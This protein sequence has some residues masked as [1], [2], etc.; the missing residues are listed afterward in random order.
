MQATRF[1][2]TAVLLCA[3]SP[4]HAQQPVIGLIT[5]TETNPFFVKMREG[6]T[7]AAKAKG[8]RLMTAAGRFDGDNASQ[9]TAIENMVAAG[10]KA[11][12]ITPSDTKAIV[13]PI[14]KARAAGVL[15]IALDSPTDPQDATDALFATDNFKAGMLIGRYAKAATAGKPAKIAM[16]DLAPGITVGTLRHDGFLQG[17][18]IKDGD[19][20]IV[21][22]ADTQGDQ[23]KGQTAMENCLQRA[24]QIDV[25]YTINE[26]AAAG[27]YRALRAAG[28]EKQVLI[29]SVDGGCAGVRNV[30]AGT[31]AATSQQYPLKMAALGVEAAVEYAKTGKK[32]TGT[33]DTG[34]T[35]IT[36]KPMKGVDSRD[37]AF[38]LDACWGK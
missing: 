28:R 9:V 24:P 16:L 8:A 19:P 2:L 6:A 7:E 5:K 30:K 36:D 13:Q 29:V 32:A 15:V 34:V 21:C 4:A 12:L 10:A 23:A 17:Y 38:G 11:I 14:R 27:A 33:V 37:T 18:G 20:A 25:V 26:P 35:L 31:L 22:R 1:I 3:T